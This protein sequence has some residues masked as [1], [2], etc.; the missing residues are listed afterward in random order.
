M[1]EGKGVVTHRASKLI[2][3]FYCRP[4][5]CLTENGGILALLHPFLL[6]SLTWQ[7]IE[8][9]TGTAWCTWLN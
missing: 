9:N 1:Q 7:S 3:A 6:F 8:L 5:L 2:L 4:A